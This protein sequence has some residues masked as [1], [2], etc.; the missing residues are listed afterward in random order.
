MTKVRFFFSVFCVIQLFICNSKISYADDG[1]Y[2]NGVVNI[3]KNELPAPGSEIKI[4]TMTIGTSHPGGDMCSGSTGPCSWQQIYIRSGGTIHTSFYL[5][6]K[7]AKVV[8][9]SPSGKKYNI[10][11]FLIPRSQPQIGYHIRYNSSITNVYDPDVSPGDK[12]HSHSVNLTKYPQYRSQYTN[13]EYIPPEALNSNSGS[14]S[15]YRNSTVCRHPGNKD[16]ALDLYMRSVPTKYDIMVTLP[17]EFKE[18]GLTFRDARVLTFNA[19]TALDGHDYSYNG[20]GLTATLILNGSFS[21]PETCS[22]NLSSQEINF[23]NVEVKS[24]NGELAKQSVELK[25][26]CTN[27][28]DNT[29]I[30]YRIEHPPTS[31][32]ELVDGNTVSILAH[33]TSNNRALGLIFGLDNENI[34]CYGSF[35]DR[36][37]YNQEYLFSHGSGNVNT[38]LT[39]KLCQYGLPASYGEKRKTFGLKVRWVKS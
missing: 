10:E 28:D 13:D 38:K 37:Q 25:S 19:M 34:S 14:G 23:G 22:F 26:T 9:D 39:F 8:A 35:K 31:G 16:C 15:I 5:N 29:K 36:N 6:Y 21:F 1:G 32:L 4:A 11:V 7:V 27:V 3:P 33:T 20:N 17:Q 24:E 12:V 18:S 30:E 2:L